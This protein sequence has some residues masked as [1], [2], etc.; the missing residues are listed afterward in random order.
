MNLFVTLFELVGTVAFAISG[1]VCGLK[2]RLDIFGILIVG[3]VTATGGG[4]LRDLILGDIPPQAFKNPIYVLISAIVSILIFLL[5][6]VGVWKV[7]VEE[8]NAYRRTLLVM[9][10]IG[11]AIFTVSGVIKGLGLYDN[12]FLAV[13]SGV[14]SGVGGGLIKDMMVNDTPYILYKH[15]YAM[16]SIAGAI[17]CGLLVRMNNELVGMWL[18]TL[19]IIMIRCLAAHFR[20]SLPKIKEK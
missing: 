7:N 17:V 14:V 8:S 20:W 13:F 2:H 11:L 15:V 9:D 6:Y 1:A 19:L 5:A 18:G 12:L 4:I 3:V 16:A 10:S